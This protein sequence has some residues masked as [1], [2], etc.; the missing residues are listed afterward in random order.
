MGIIEAKRRPEIAFSGQIKEMVK[1]TNE[2][3]RSDLYRLEKAGCASRG[4]KEG[5]LTKSLALK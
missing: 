2:R 1:G 4:M 5:T 3:E